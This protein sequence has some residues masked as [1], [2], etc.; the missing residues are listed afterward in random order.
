[1]DTQRK[2]HEAALSHLRE[3]KDKEIADVKAQSDAQEQMYK[4]ETEK[5][6]RRKDADL[7]AVKKQGEDELEQQKSMTVEAEEKCQR[8]EKQLSGGD[9]VMKE[10]QARLE[11]VRNR[12]LIQFNSQTT[13]LYYRWNWNCQLQTKL[14]KQLRNSC[15][16]PE[17]QLK[18]TP[19]NS[20]Q[21]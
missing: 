4:K 19:M 16:D 7:E 1:M 10:M 13:N 18:S 11:K 9:A 21:S 8:L 3:V 15:L 17:K 5:L 14:G 20:Y 6:G 2:N 12:Q